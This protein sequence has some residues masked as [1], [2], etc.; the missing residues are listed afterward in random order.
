MNDVNDNAPLLQRELNQVS[1]R[2]RRLIRWTSLATLFVILAIGGLA[3]LAWA[4]GSNHS[5]PGFVLLLLALWA[6]Q[7]VST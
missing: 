7:G 3:T 1:L 5:F 4:R 2:Y 6:P